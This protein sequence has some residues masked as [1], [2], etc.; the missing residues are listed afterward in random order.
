[1][2]IVFEELAKEYP[3]VTFLRVR[4][5][6]QHL[7]HHSRTLH[8]KT[9]VGTSVSGQCAFQVEA[10]ELPDISEKYDVSAVPFFALLK[11]TIN[12]SHLTASHYISIVQLH[13]QHIQQHL[14]GTAS[15]LAYKLQS[16]TLLDC[17]YRRI[18]N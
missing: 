15:L 17:M 7:H 3:V 13:R 9:T 1:M 11:V 8:L 2:D 14:I 10:E 4:Q 16:L 6:E 5:A 12:C 18:T